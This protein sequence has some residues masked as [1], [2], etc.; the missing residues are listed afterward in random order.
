MITRKQ[1][2]SVFG[3]GAFEHGLFYL[4][5]GALRFELSISGSAIDIFVCA[6]DKARKLCSEIFGEGEPIG[7]CLSFYGGRNFL[8]ALSFFRELEDSGI[9]IPKN[10][11]C[12]RIRDPEEEDLYR[13][14]ILF[15]TPY[16]SLIRLVWGALAQDLGVRPRIKGSTYIFSLKKSVLIHPYDDRGMDIISPNRQL[17]A[18]L[19]QKY[20][21]WLLDYDRD[22]MDKV[23]SV[24]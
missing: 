7:V 11:E 4:H 22:E 3:E 21:S 9:T 6:L 23:Y 15:E 16:S 14:F 20:N 24:L 18:G 1:T 17:L 8:S 12:W 19:Y 5:E 2:Q 10:S 13:H